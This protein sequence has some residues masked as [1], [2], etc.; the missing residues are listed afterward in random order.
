V[1]VR[2]RRWQI[3]IAVTLSILA[4]LFYGLRWE[5]YP[6][7]VM[8]NEMGRYLIDDVAFLFIQVLLVSM[9]VDG[10]IQRRTREATFNKLNMVIGAFFSECGSDLLGQLAQ[11]DTRLAEVQADVVAIAD[12]SAPQYERARRS[13]REHRPHIDLSACD[14]TALRHRL[15]AEKPFLLGLLSNQALLEHE[16]FTDLLWAVTHLAEELAARSDLEA[17]PGPDARHL[18]AD[19]ERAFTRLALQWVDYLDHLQAQYPYLFSL[20]IRTSP[21]DPA[22]SATIVA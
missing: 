14:L 13:L 11:A 15:N 12:W 18:T 20:A 10:F 3:E 4:L 17:L 8:H 7:R 9:L 16:A 21:L 22:A 1:N 5:L 6:G 19:V 2:F